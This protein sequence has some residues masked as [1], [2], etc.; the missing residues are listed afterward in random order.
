[1]AREP[2]PLSLRV[3][4][5]CSATGETTAAYQVDEKTA[6]QARWEHASKETIKRTAKPCPRCRVPV[7]KHGGCMHM[8]CP[9]PQCQLEWCWNCG[10]E[11]NRA[12]MGDHWFDV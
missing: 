2:W 11:W 12:C 10:R 7:E 8:K 4:S 3:R 1:W 9:Q 6:E 5:L